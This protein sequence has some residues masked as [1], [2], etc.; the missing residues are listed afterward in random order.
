MIGSTQLLK[1]LRNAAAH[2]CT[3]TANA[4]YKSILAS[5]DVILNEL[6]LQES[7]AFYLEFRQGGNALLLQGQALAKERG[8]Q[9]PGLAATRTD[10]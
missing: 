7:P 10:G 2:I 1:H 3:D 4:E 6:L 8:K 9:P 5:A